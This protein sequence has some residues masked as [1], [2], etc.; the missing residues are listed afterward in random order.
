MA[1]TQPTT[2]DAAGVTRTAEGQIADLSPPPT[3]TPPSTPAPT[4]SQ[5]Q[6]STEKLSDAPA[7]SLL[8]EEGAKEGAPE[9]YTD[10]TVP[11]GFT[12]DE[13]VAKDAGELFKRLDLSQPHAQELVDF[14]I[15]QTK[16]A[17]EA[18]FNAYQD[19]RQEWRDEINGDPEI[20][21]TKLNGVKASI[22]KL[23]DSFGDRKIAEAF[24]E[25]MDFTGAGDNPAVVRGLY[26]LSKRLNEGAAVRGNGPSP[27]GQRA[28][29][30]GER[31]AAQA[32]YPNL[33]STAR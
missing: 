22:G 15:K 24:R 30:S 25:A 9:K 32:L 2:A 21:G 29:G 20:G 6:T 12:L 16:E 10:F 1:E 26:A 19:K 27:E 18:P 31:S 11:E 4:T 33:P 8:N 3:S 7:K 23:I 28:P 13:Q 5:P 17:F 14:Y